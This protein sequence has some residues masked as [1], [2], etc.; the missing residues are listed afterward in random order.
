M[1]ER[2]LAAELDR[3]MIALG[4]GG[5]SFDTIALFGAR[6]S[7]PHGVPSLR[8]A[9]RGDLCLV[10]FGALVEGYASDMT[11]VLAVGKAT[12]RQAR[13]YA[14]IHR[15]YWKGRRAVCGRERACGH[16]RAL[17]TTRGFADSS[18]SPGPGS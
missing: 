17:T 12:P 3:R 4:A 13:I 16:G 6:T 8:R 9:R 2:E 1:T 10:D 14:A 5:P 7:L 18:T 15:A 11:R